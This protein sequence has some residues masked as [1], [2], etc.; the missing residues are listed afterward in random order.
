[1][2]IPAGIAAIGAGVANAQSAASTREQ[3]RFQ[4][5]MRA[6]QYQT[7]V[8]DMRAAGLN[9]ALAYG[10]GG[11]G[12]LSGAATRYENVAEAGVRGL[13]AAA[14]AREAAARADLV[15]SQAVINKAQA[16]DLIDQIRLRNELIEQQ[17]FTSAAQADAA[18]ERAGQ[19]NQSTMNLRQTNQWI[20]ATWDQ[21]IALIEQDLK[22][23]GL[24]VSQA[25]IE[26]TL[27][28]LSQPQAEAE[29]A[30]YEGPGKYSP[31][32]NTALDVV[33]A[34]MPGFGILSRP[35]AAPRTTNVYVRPK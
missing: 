9:P 17:K 12:N 31:Y 1:M 27:L 29:A 16:A 34:L 13:S 11:S 25:E 30:F 7:A 14:N 8:R 18:R 15:G 28:R 32:V 33:K 10:Q 5:R 24:E 35:K 2:T 4:E 22:R 26:N 3:M 19:I 20:A 6:T 21:R 23:R